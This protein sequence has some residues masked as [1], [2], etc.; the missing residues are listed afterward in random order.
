MAGVRP[1]ATT[2]AAPS[3]GVSNVA[4]GFRN[5]GDTA[6]RGAG[7]ADG[8]NGGAAGAGSGDAG[9]GVVSDAAVE[10][11]GGGRPIDPGQVASAN[12]AVRERND[13][14]ISQADLVQELD[15]RDQA[16]EARDT[17]VREESDRRDAVRAASDDA[18][19]R[20]DRARE[21]HRSVAR[22]LMQSGSRGG[23][24]LH[25]ILHETHQH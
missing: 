9:G 10:S 20:R 5:A 14:P 1:S 3:P 16:R 6:G 2:A 17:A 8:G 4:A 19:R 18:V 23:Q 11:D 22:A 25:R 12:A 7:A 13:R 15:R 24:F 21:R